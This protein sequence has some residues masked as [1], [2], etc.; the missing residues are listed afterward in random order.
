MFFY[1]ML[2]K[3][4]FLLLLMPLF[5]FGQTVLRGTISNIEDK[6]GIHVFNEAFQRFTVTD[7][8]GGFEISATVNDVIGFSGIQYELRTIL[9]TE[10]HIESGF[11]E[12][13]LTEKVNE[14][15]VV[16]IG[17]KL[18]GDLSIDAKYIETVVPMEIALTDS[19]RGLGKYNGTLSSDGQSA[20]ESNLI[21]QGGN[22]LG[23]IGIMIP[24]SNKVKTP[25]IIPLDYSRDALVIY[26]GGDFFSGHLKMPK[27]DEE[28]FIQFTELDSIIVVS[29]R[30]RNKFELLHRVLQLR[31]K[32]EISE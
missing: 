20:I 21:P 16:F 15:D 2:N 18:T 23:L 12:V 6:E 26:Y 13:L 10:K 22:I 14:L 4:C 11:L 32:F 30:K 24:K 29:L 1:K 3:L 17:Y 9:I 25:E 19:F 8:Y 31:E 5:S 27:G 28:R 7:E